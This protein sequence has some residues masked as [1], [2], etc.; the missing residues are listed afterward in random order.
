MR[1]F[2]LSLTGPFPLTACTVK[3]YKFSA[4]FVNAAQGDELDESFVL[5]SSSRF[6]IDIM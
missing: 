4:V 2:E 6:Y 1:A 5:L 3:I